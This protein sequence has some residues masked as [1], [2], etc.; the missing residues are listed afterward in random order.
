MSLQE[1]LLKIYGKPEAKPSPFGKPATVQ[2]LTGARPATPAEIA[3]AIGQEV[4]T[5][6]DYPP[7]PEDVATKGD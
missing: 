4:P 5:E 7:T 1:K 2:D 6:A 3:R